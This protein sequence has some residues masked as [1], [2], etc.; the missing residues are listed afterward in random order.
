MTGT[1]P[2]YGWE[3]VN[4]GADAVSG[5]ANF[6]HVP[7]IDA[8]LGRIA[9]NIVSMW[10]G[11]TSIS[12][13]ANEVTVTPVTISPALQGD[14]F[15]A[16]VSTHSEVP[17]TVVEVSAINETSTGFDIC[18]YRTN[19]TNYSVNWVLYGIREE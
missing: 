8:T 19:D 5:P 1:T 12:A 4:S 11:N 7:E 16:I 3:Y 10:V 6:A 2:N 15:L 13:V 14:S 18:G 9:G 17:G